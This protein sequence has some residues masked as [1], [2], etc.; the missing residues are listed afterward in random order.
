MAE[1]LSVYDFAF[2]PPGRQTA[3][4]WGEEA[5]P[6]SL[7]RFQNVRIPKHSGN[8]TGKP[9]QMSPSSVRLA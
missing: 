4:P 3:C 7:F 6:V 8:G 5:F 2:W 1:A 9:R